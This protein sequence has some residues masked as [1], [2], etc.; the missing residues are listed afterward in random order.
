MD[1]KLSYYN[2]ISREQW[3][4][5]IGGIETIKYHHC[6]YWLD[7]CG[8]FHNVMENKS[9]I[10]MDNDETPLA[11]C[12]LFLSEI[13]GKRE[14]SVN[15][16][17]IGVPAL[18]G[19]IK[20]SQ[21]RKLMDIIFGIINEYA[22]KNKAERIVM[23]SHPLTRNVCR[24]EVY[25][26]RNTFEMLRYN[27]LCRVENTL[28]IDL[29]LPQETLSQNMGK[30]QRRHISRGSKKGIK[31]EAFSRDGNNDRLE[32]HFSGFQQ[33]HF[34]S[35]GRITRPQKTW[36]SMHRAAADGGATLFCA[37]LDDT[38]MSYLFCGQFD[39]MAFGW[40]QVNI[41]EFEQEYSPRHILEWEAML[42]YKQQGYRYY[43]VG[44]RFYCPQLLYTPSAKELTISEFKERYGGFM[45]PKISWMGY[46]DKERMKRELE[47]QRQ[48]YLS[49]EN[50]VKIPGEGD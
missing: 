37:F 3:D 2:N 40:S 48:E 46:Y 8:R 32:Q 13:D 43:E 5:W 20:P 35:A 38:P 45:L 44:E 11:V 16:A 47:Q 31:V 30:Y 1:Y 6:W 29:K 9:F 22:A 36:D 41:E 21:G 14:I 18:K 4:G 12:P 28:V 10:L 27:M 49:V 25:G 42:Y 19:D 39:A 33:A 15:G 50:L 34:A 26:Y 23:L 7:Y 24:D 17:P